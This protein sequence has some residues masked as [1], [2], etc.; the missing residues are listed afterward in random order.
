MSDHAEPDADMSQDSLLI[1][2][3]PP[4]ATPLQEAD[5]GLELP[6]DPEAAKQL[7]LGELAE[8]RAT[9]GEYL[10]AM[11]R[12][13]AEFDNFRKRVDRDRGELVDMA[14]SRLIADML[15]TLDNFDAALAYDPQTPA[16]EKILDGMKST[17]TQLLDLLHGAGLEPV[18]T[19]GTAF[20]PAVHEAVSG[21]TGSGDGDLVVADELRRGYVLNGRLIRAALVTVDHASQIDEPVEVDD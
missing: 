6:D 7:L 10:D 19:I 8:S 13:A 15:P 16:E 1:D 2:E 9:A 5:L 18:A 12:L 4:A 14:T 11:Q 20:D 21:P 3:E 17:R